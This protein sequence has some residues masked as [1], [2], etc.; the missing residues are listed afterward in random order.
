[1]QTVNVAN[2]VEFA[3]LLEGAVMAALE[4]ELTR[5]VANIADPNTVA[6]Q[7]RTM[8]LQMELTPSPNRDFID[9]LIKLKSSCNQHNPPL[10]AFLLMSIAPGREGVLHVSVG[11]HQAHQ[12]SLF[13]PAPE[14]RLSSGL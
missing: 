1:M 8:T 13:E 5:L 7:K 4:A 11:E 2:G 3:A 10:R 6:V 12:Q 14:N 9:M